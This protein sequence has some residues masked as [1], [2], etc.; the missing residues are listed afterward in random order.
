MAT[1]STNI[2]IDLSENGNA[3]NME[4]NGSSLLSQSQNL[5]SV[6]FTLGGKPVMD[7]SLG[8]SFSI[9]SSNAS[10]VLS[11]FIVSAPGGGVTF[12][13]QDLNLYFPTLNSLIGT[14]S[15]TIWLGK[16]DR[17]S[18]SSYSDVLY[19]YSGNDTIY[20]GDG[21]DTIDGGSGVNDIDGG[22]GTDTLVRS[23]RMSSSTAV[24]YNGYV[25]VGD[26]VGY[27]KTAG[28]EYVRYYDQ[29]V[30]TATVAGFD[31]LAYLAANRDLAAAFGTNGDAAVTHYMSSGARERRPTSF[32]GLSYIA[33]NPDLAAV[34]GTN[35]AAATTHYITSG[36]IEGRSTSFNAMSYLAANPDLLG[37]FGTNT[38]AA[39]QHFIASGRLEGRSTTFNATAYL[40]RN[41]D[42]QKA[43]GTSL[44]A[45]ATHYVTSG[46]REGRS[47][48]PLT[49]ATRVADALPATNEAGGVLAFGAV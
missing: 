47:A 36:R 33:A 40:A 9:T 7:V 15:P 31:A 24:A 14:V 46:Y 26:G 4:F 41:P 13:F 27:D 3:P 43:L 5:I 35:A 39:T 29:T 48:A 17:I 28:I 11:Y 25:Y 19:G 1:F 37:V 45:A 32:D 44:L 23:T 34:F 12:A 22:S 18:G 10:G 8:G 21:N 30:S 6:R 38:A 2:A 49:A 42:V 16:A 20:G